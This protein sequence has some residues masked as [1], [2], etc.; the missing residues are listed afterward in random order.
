MPIWLVTIRMPKDLIR[1]IYSGYDVEQA[2]NKEPANA[3]I[4]D[5]SQSVE[6]ADE[7]APEGL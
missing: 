6:T 2:Y 3:E 5:G 4:V 1:T 7:I